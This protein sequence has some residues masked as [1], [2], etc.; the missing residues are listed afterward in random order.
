MSVP[1]RHN[2]TLAEKR[3]Y[4]RGYQNAAS[5]R[6]PTDWP[7]APPEPV[8]RNM[9]D[10]L[11]RIHCHVDGL[12]ATIDPA[13]DWVHLLDAILIEADNAAGAVTHWLRTR[14]EP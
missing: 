4:M 11:E 10:A 5:R 1:A 8:V 7:P 13:D 6:W 3:A 9:L 2:K 14:V 12:R